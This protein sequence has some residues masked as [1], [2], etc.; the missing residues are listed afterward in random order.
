MGAG[1]GLTVAL[2]L[3]Q[4][5]DS[6]RKDR[7]DQRTQFV[8]TYEDTIKAVATRRTDD[9]ILDTKLQTFSES[10]GGLGII[11]LTKDADNRLV[12]AVSARCTKATR[13]R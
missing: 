10:M 7:D 5:F 4:T 13:R 11:D 2:G 9:L 6:Y 8:T 3:W 12:A 1:I